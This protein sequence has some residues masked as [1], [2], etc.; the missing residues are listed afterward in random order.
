MW[1]DAN[2]QISVTLV[3]PAAC[4]YCFTWGS[5]SGGFSLAVTLVGVRGRDR[6]LH[7]SWHRPGSP[8]AAHRGELCTGILMDTCMS[9]FQALPNRRNSDHVLHEGTGQEPQEGVVLFGIPPSLPPLLPFV[10]C[11][12]NSWKGP[13]S[14]LFPLSPNPACSSHEL[15]VPRHFLRP[16]TRAALWTT[17]SSLSSALGGN[18]TVSPITERLAG[19]NG[20]SRQGAKPDGRARCPTRGWA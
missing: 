9:F 15:E 13:K 2:S 19:A 1:F 8:T 16:C 6:F 11:T 20:P 12:V 18:W 17:C 10:D 3:W 5:L 7:P 4:L 14:P